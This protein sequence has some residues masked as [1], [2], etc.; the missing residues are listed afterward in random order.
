MPIYDLEERRK[1]GREWISNRRKQW[2][3]DKV[4]VDCGSK[5]NLE[6]DHVIPQDK[7]SHK[8]WSWSRERREVELAKCVARCHKCHKKKTAVDLRN[9]RLIKGRV[10]HVYMASGPIPHG[11]WS[12]YIDHG[13]R[14]RLCRR[15]LG[16]PRDQVITFEHY[17]NIESSKVVAPT[18]IEPVLSALK[19]PRVNQLHHGAR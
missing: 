1:Y 11:T 10:R 5:E 8:I 15:S 9:T 14:C 7:A 12:G 19:G 3:S 16:F 4:C 18:G 2:F 17:L 13:C 6:L